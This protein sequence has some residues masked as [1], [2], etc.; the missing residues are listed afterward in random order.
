MFGRG[1]RNKPEHDRPR[2]PIELYEAG[3]GDW[4]TATP[5]LHA[6]LSEAERGHQR[7]QD[8]QRFHACEQAKPTPRDEVGATQPAT[9]EQ[10][11]DWLAGYFQ[12]GGTP[13][14]FY[15]YP[16]ERLGFEYATGPIRID[17][18]HEYGARSRRIIVPHHVSVTCSNP[19]GSFGGWAHT[20]LY[21]LHDY[22]TQ[23]PNHWV[24]IYS[25]PEFDDLLTDEHRELQRQQEAQ[26]ERFSNAHELPPARRSTL[27]VTG[28]DDAVLDLLA[29]AH[30]GPNASLKLPSG[31]VLGAA[32]A[33]A[34]TCLYSDETQ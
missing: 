8:G 24:P 13:T 23:H 4:S 32:E 31:T 30:F 7:N 18:N 27:P 19:G 6:L 20:S 29:G 3:G 15:P 33:Q 2:S 14:H 34:W 28:D 21:Y 1:R 11:R 26:H 17:S 9:L 22:R 10:Y 16:F 5:R 25:N 12:R